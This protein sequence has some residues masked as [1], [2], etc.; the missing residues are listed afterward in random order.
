[1][2]M[3]GFVGGKLKLRLKL[4]SLMT[5]LVKRLEWGLKLHR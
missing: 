5:S 3:V 1:M 4:K 2:T